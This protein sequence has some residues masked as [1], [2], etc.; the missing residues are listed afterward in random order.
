MKMN[1]STSSNR[2]KARPT[3][4]S[5]QKRV[6]KWEAAN[7]PEAAE[8]EVTLGVCEEV[9][10]IADCVVKMARGIRVDEYSEERLRD[11]LGDAVVY[12]M[13]ICSRRGWSLHDVISDTVREVV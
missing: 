3:L 6:A 11:A 5:L 12:M 7:F 10:E 1:T 8:W 9:G 4:D 13:G 2:S